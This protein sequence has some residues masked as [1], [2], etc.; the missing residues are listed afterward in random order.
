MI[1]EEYTN[2]ELRTDIHSKRQKDEPLRKGE[3]PAGTLEEEFLVE[4][5]WDAS[6]K[7][8]I[9]EQK[10]ETRDEIKLTADIPL[11][12]SG[13]REIVGVRFSA[14]TFETA[15]T[16]RALR[17][18]LKEEPHLSY[19]RK[20]TAYSTAEGMAYLNKNLRV[21]KNGAE[22][23]FYENPFYT[24]EGAEWLSRVRDKKTLLTSLETLELEIENEARIYVEPLELDPNK[25][26][27]KITD[28]Y[29][30]DGRFRLRE[31]NRAMRYSIKVPLFN[32]DT[33]KTKACIRLEWKPDEKGESI[34]RQLRDR[35]ST[36]EGTRTL[37]KQGQ[38]LPYILETGDLWI[39]TNEGG[40]Y[41]LEFDTVEGI[42][43]LP[44]EIRPLSYQ[45]S[46]LKL[47]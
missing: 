36:L 27:N 29:A 35:I 19:T 8:R 28:T 10:G 47:K 39:N 15:E 34:L 14:N 45:K 42:P 17:E 40:K 12:N 26:I 7:I 18:L 2:L 21:H 32:R 5:T 30:L 20:V 43:T 4:D 24:E 9:R 22:K 37:R 13:W 25:P 16:L 23:N 31:K 3:T 11:T 33:D 41:W 46:E 44:A 38:K 6:G 1:N